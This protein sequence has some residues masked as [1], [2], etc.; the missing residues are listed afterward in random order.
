MLLKC[1]RC[2]EEYPVELVRNVKYAVKEVFDLVYQE[3]EDPLYLCP[4]CNRML[5][6]FMKMESDRDVGDDKD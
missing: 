5:E 1:D 2:G 6:K 4:E 3:V